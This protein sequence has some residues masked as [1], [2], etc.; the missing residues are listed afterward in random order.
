M[1]LLATLCSLTTLAVGLA[2]QPTYQ[3]L[4]LADATTDEAKPNTNFGTQPSLLF[5]EFHDGFG[6][7]RARGYLRFDMSGFPVPP[8]RATLRWYQSSA[9]GAGC[10]PVTLHRV[11]GSW[12][13]T[14]ITWANQPGF[15]PAAVAEMCVGDIF[16][17]GWH[18]ADITGL[19]KQWKLGQVSNYGIVIRDQ[20]EWNVGASRPGI[21]ESREST[22]P[23]LRPYL[24]ITFMNPFGTACAALG[25][26]LPQLT[27]A[28]IPVRR[29]G[30]LVLS[31]SNLPPNAPCTLLIG[32]SRTTWSGISLPLGLGLFGF[33]GCTLLVS[34]EMQQARTSQASGY[35]GTAIS[36]P[37]L[38][39]LSGA[40][41]YCQLAVADAQSRVWFTNALDCVV[42]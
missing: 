35:Y 5:G 4:P 37:N 40:H 8:A 12:T 34:G 24:E 41:L 42:W 13:E 23:A 9:T 14:T 15:D 18:E 17:P 21:G 1:K 33:P 20:Y 7:H 10:L 3:L 29:N 27:D 19:V 36:I 16:A 25:Q 28:G 26:P 32:A 30:S 39:E 31:G 11:I 38:P 22:N 2:A 6:Y